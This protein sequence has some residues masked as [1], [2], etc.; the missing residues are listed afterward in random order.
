VAIEK[1]GIRLVGV[2]RKRHPVVLR[3]KGDQD[4]GVA[5]G[6]SGDGDC[7]SDA[8]E[9]VH[10]SLIR[11]LT[12]RG[13]EDDGASSSARTTGGSRV[14]AQSTTASTASSRR[15]RCPGGSTI[16][17][18]AAPTT[19]A[20]TS[21]TSRARVDHNVAKGNVSGFEL[22]NSSRIRA[23]HNLSTG[24]TGGITN[25]CVALNVPAADCAALDIEPNPDGT[26]TRGNKAKNNGKAPDSSVPAPF[27]VDLAWDTT[28]TDNC[29][30]GN[31]AGTTF[32]SPLPACP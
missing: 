20:T 16:P 11:G 13:F 27:A 31:K 7:L 14:C 10:G 2:P 26:R 28:G 1:N 22:E 12:V 15:T 21:G 25:Y 5:V 17:S 24:N 18:R 19:P 8:S 6:K 30:S 32:P 9:R 3:P 4:E 29:W 23:D